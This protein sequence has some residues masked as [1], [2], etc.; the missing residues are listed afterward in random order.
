MRV[1]NL[2]PVVTVDI[3]GVPWAKGG[4][5]L[6]EQKSRDSKKVRTYNH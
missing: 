1:Q 6:R 4:G 5:R 3:E 2:T